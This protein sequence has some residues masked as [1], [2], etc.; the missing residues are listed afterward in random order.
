MPVLYEK[1]G[2]IGLVTLSRP[3]A[4]NCWGE[5]FAQGLLERFSALASD[6]DIHCAI[7]TGDEA[8][9]AFCAGANLKDPNTHTV[10]S[11][12]Q[13]IKTIPEFRNFVVNVLHDFPK[14]VIAAVNGYAIG[15]GCIMTFCCDLVVA[16]EQAEWRLTQSQLGILPAY[17]AT[18][19]LARWI[20]KA[21]AMKLSL[22]FPIKAQ[23]AL[24]NGL[25]QWVAPHDQ[26]MKEAFG[27]AEHI[28]AQP[29]LAPR[30]VKESMNNGL[31]IPNLAQAALADV[32]RFM[33]LELTEDKKEGHAAWRE[34]RQP[35]FRGL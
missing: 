11:P 31:D 24:R 18:A 9:R 3:E 12:S 29:A 10:E 27:V 19:R 4:R 28:A 35:H 21:N 6:D 34:R 14:P 25:A 1:R 8:G 13:F 20:G 33:A 5:D 2:A 16:S 30:L 7:L 23:E 32:Y 22:G 17:G 15:V 26:L